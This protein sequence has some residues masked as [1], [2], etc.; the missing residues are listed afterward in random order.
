VRKPNQTLDR[1]TR[2]AV[3]RRFQCGHCGRAPRHRSALRSAAPGA[4]PLLTVEMTV[5]RDRRVEKGF[6]LIELL[7]VIAIIAILA[8]LLLPTLRR[9]KDA[10]DS[11]V[12]KNNLRQMSIACSFYV[13][14]F[15]AYPAGDYSVDA[16]QTWDKRGWMGSLAKYAGIEKPPVLWATSPA[17][18]YQV[19][20]I[21]RTIFSCPGYVKARGS[22][23]GECAAYG[24]NKGG[25]AQTIFPQDFRNGRRAQLGLGG[26]FL[27]D[28]EASA[29][30]GDAFMTLPYSIRCIRE[31]EVPNPS[32][33]LGIGDSYFAWLLEDPP[34]GPRGIA[35]VLLGDPDLSAGFI[36][37][38]TF[39]PYYEPRFAKRRHNG[40]WN[41]LFCDG[42]VQ[43]VRL[44]QFQ[45]WR[46]DNVRRLWNNDHEPHWE[47]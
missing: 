43:T 29:P 39:W 46:N 38:S 22:F 1:M 19:F 35:G 15:N 21:G 40:R 31:N 11:A 33:M 41:M 34:G 44:E 4:N 24:Y 2:S 9:A 18:V 42:H 6:T 23:S 13:A 37:Y 32:E 47:F 36:S 25:V 30:N 17:N 10:A 3:G 20:D 16:P 27:K 7:V 14:E 5:K 12:C 45:D 26:E 8:A 28:I